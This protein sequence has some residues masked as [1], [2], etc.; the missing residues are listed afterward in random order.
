MKLETNDFGF[1]K[2]TIEAPAVWGA[3]LIVDVRGQSDTGNRVE[4]VHDRQSL[5]AD[6]D[7]AKTNLVARLDGEKRGDGAISALLA[8]LSRGVR[9]CRIDPTGREN[10]D[11]TIRG[12]RFRGSPNASHGYIYVTGTLEN[13]DTCDGCGTGGA[14][15]GTKAY[16]GVCQKCADE[17]K[18]DARAAK[19][20]AKS[21]AQRLGY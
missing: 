3:R 17:L 1:N 6:T 11:R 8:F 4:L 15:K 9:H 14:F 21:P 18:A 16:P 2:D 10:F 13:V 12:V 20:R 5:R 19:S 7:E